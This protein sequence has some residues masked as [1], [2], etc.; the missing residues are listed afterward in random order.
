M[1][2]HYL[3]G[4][5]NSYSSN[6]KPPH[7]LAGGIECPVSPW[8]LP[9]FQWHNTYN[10]F[11]IL[12]TYPKTKSNTPIHTGRGLITSHFWL[13][14]PLKLQHQT[15]QIKALVCDLECPYDLILGRTPMAQLSAWQDY[16]AHKLYLQQISIPLIVR[17]NIRILPGKTGILTLTL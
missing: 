17:N 12:H 13:E 2:H 4:G 8:D 1:H 16:A 5:G 6:L 10:K 9:P 7:L 11:P 3:F 14:I 15:I